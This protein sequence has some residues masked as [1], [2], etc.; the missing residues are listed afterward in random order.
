MKRQPT[1]HLRYAG[2]KRFY[3]IEFS[4]LEWIVRVR[5]LLR[6]SFLRFLPGLLVLPALI[7]LSPG[8]ANAQFS[9]DNLEFGGGYVHVSGDFGLNGFNLNTALW[10]DRR[11]ALAFDYDGGY[12]NSRIGVLDLT[13]F[14]STA[15]NSHI[16]NFLIGPRFFFPG[17]KIKKYHFEPFAEVQIGGTHLSQKVQQLSGPTT[18]SG[19]A[20]SFAW[21]IG[22]G[23]DYH[24]TSQWTGRLKLDFLRTHLVSEGQSRWRLALGVAYTIRPRESER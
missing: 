7:L 17:R 10:M 3:P 4:S 12:N 21:L 8:M 19:S 16:Q 6:R 13:S 18:V 20:S 24:F 14:G 22:G 2:E 5:N 23:A 9:P 15:I 11:V 1:L